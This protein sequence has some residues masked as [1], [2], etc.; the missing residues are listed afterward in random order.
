MSER[1]ETDMILW[2]NVDFPKQLLDSLKDYKIP[3]SVELEDNGVLVAKRFDYGG[4]FSIGVI[5]MHPEGD[6]CIGANWP[7]RAEMCDI[8]R[9]ML[10]SSSYVDLAELACQTQGGDWEHF[11][12]SPWI[13][14]DDPEIRTCFD[15][16]GKFLAESPQLRSMLVEWLEYE[17]EEA[18]FID[19]LFPDLHEG[20]VGYAI[21]D[22]LPASEVDLL[23]L[24]TGDFR[25]GPGGYAERV[26]YRGDPLV[27]EAS[28]RT[29]HIPFTLL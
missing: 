17:D 2:S 1:H 15:R 3:L 8:S 20:L 4:P 18:P 16:K 27:L 11:E 28:L 26:A 12:D 5:F 29:W 19:G 10:K 21:R 22:A 23:D 7:T 24:A 9:E 25:G 6:I 13:K 14:S